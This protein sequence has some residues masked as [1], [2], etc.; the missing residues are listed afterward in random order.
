MANTLATVM[1]LQVLP[2]MLALL[3]ECLA[4][5]TFNMGLNT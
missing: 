2:K 4:K 3:H 1:Q 5:D